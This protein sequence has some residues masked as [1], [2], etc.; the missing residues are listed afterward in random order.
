MSSFRSEQPKQTN[1]N[2]E[3]VAGSE[4]LG[5]TNGRKGGL[6]V[7]KELKS[8]DPNRTKWSERTERKTEI[9]QL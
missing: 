2:A 1:Q 4:L 9:I 5:N 7:S 8:S 3:E 6:G